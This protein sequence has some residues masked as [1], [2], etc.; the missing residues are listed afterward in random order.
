MSYVM[1]VVGIRSSTMS[2]A[3]LVITDQSPYYSKWKPL[4]FGSQEQPEVCAWSQVLSPSI[5]DVI[6]VCL[7]GLSRQVS[8]ISPLVI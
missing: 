3:Y 8:A 4:S 2:A 5:R 6:Q 1:R 7:C